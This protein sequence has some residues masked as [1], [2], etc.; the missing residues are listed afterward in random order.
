IAFLHGLAQGVPVLTAEEPGEID[1]QPGDGADWRARDGRRLVIGEHDRMFG[2]DPAAR[3]ATFLAVVLV[4]DQDA[5]VLI[6]AVDAEQ[7][8]IDA[9]HA[10]RAPAIVDHGVPAASRRLQEGV[11][12]KRRGTF[13]ALYAK[14]NQNRGRLWFLV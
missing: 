8:E 7:A 10:V 3:G 1:L 6:D 5:G 4:V 9:L 14:L 2:T 12:R 13:R 11:G